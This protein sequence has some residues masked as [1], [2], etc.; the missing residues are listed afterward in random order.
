MTTNITGAIAD[1]RQMADMLA[2]HQPLLE[3]FR[4]SLMWNGIQFHVADVDS[5]HEI[6]A[7]FGGLD[8]FTVTAIGDRG[9]TLIV[10]RHFGA[11][12]VC[13]LGAT[14]DLCEPVETPALQLRQST[15]TAASDLVT[16]G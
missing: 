2:E 6:T 11:A 16:V 4:A 14:S 9:A 5:L 3:R 15:T 7:A 8:Q 10:E 13:L 12:R 1:L